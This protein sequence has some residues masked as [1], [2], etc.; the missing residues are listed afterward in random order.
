MVGGHG[1]EPQ[2][3][4][5]QRLVGAPAPRYSP[6]LRTGFEPVLS[7]LRGLRVANYTNGAWRFWKDSN[8]LGVFRRDA[9]ILWQ[10]HRS[11]PIPGM[12]GPHWVVIPVRC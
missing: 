6:V 11:I 1:V 10:K 4:Q 2:W 8:L 5:L 3:P 9:A 7:A 12:R